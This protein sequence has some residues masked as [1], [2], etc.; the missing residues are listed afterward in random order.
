[1]ADA[2]A[3]YVVVVGVD[4]SE[5]GERALNEAVR[6]AAERHDAA[7]HVVHVASGYGPMLR[8]DLPED[9]RTVSVE[10]AESHL[11]GYVAARH[12]GLEASELTT[13]VRVGAASDEVVH[14][15]AD[16]SADLIVIGT[17]GRTGVRRLLLGSVA[18]SVVRRAGC[19]VLVV[20]PKDYSG[21]KLASPEG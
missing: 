11:A 16:V 13:H 21:T 1:M 15:A 2:E 3:R 12:D 19:P 18:E 5:T 20:R 17:H 10:E 9:V 7:L 6:L 4:F 14:L 8:L